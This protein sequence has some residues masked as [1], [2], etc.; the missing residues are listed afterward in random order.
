M[1]LITNGSDFESPQEMP[2]SVVI[3]HNTY[4]NDYLFIL[5][6]HE[7][8]SQGIDPSKIREYVKQQ[9]CSDFSDDD[10]EI[11]YYQKQNWSHESN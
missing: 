3:V 11:I 8:L 4:T 7:E 5:L 1:I 9:Y 6:S 2:Q 10:L